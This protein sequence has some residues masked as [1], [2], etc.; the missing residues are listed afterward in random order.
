MKWRV[1]GRQLKHA[2]RPEIVYNTYRM[3]SSGYRRM[4]KDFEVRF[5]LSFVVITLWSSLPQI[6]KKEDDLKGSVVIYLSY[7]S[8]KLSGSYS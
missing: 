5:V 8:L 2:A 7:Q 4:L 6:H 1:V 3:I